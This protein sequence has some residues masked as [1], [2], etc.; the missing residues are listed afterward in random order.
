MTDDLTTLTSSM[1]GIFDS[2]K[3]GGLTIVGGAIAIGIIFIGAK[4]LWG[5][6]RQWLAKV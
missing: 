5:K 6:T 1:T 3:T 4:W 2:V